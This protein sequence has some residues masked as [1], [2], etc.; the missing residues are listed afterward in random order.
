MVDRRNSIRSTLD[1]PAWLR[2]EAALHGSPAN[3]VLAAREGSGLAVNG[4]D[5]SK[6]FAPARPMTGTPGCRFEATMLR[7]TTRF[8]PL[9]T[10]ATATI[11][12]TTPGVR[13]PCWNVVPVPG[14]VPATESAKPVFRCCHRSVLLLAADPGADPRPATNRSTR[15]CLVPRRIEATGRP[16]PARKEVAPGA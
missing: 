13:S 5:C 7:P 10:A 9:P 3:V 15:P 14:G 1:D 4:T 16:R 2:N 6:G 11:P 8:R 12:G